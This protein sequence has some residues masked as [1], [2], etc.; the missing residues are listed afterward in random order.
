MK[1]QSWIWTAALWAGLCIAGLLLAKRPVVQ[2]K[3]REAEKGELA[4]RGN[5]I[6]RDSGKEAGIYEAD[7]SLLWR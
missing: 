4:S 7:F 2:A 5:L 3:D 1:K 6:Y